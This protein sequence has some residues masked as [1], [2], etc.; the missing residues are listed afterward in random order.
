MSNT[1]VTKEMVDK[2]LE[3]HEIITDKVYDVSCL[4]KKINPEKYT[5]F[6]HM[7]Y[8]DPSLDNFGWGGWDGC[9]GCYDWKYSSI[10]TKYIYDEQWIEE[11]KQQ[12]QI[13]RE[14]QEKQASIKK[15]KRKERQNKK[16]K[17]EYERLKKKFG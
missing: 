17:D 4:L 15:Q 8:F 14:Q 16:E 1:K 9:M 12:I 6:A 11:T 7:E 2:Y 10:P 13:E 5:S 3:L